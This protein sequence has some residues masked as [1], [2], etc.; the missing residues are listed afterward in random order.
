MIRKC[1]LAKGMFSRKI[2]LA[3][4]IQSKIGGRT[5]RSKFSVVNIEYIV[6]GRLITIQFIHT[7]MTVHIQN[8]FS[9]IHFAS[10]GQILVLWWT[11]NSHN[12][13]FPRWLFL[14]WFA[15]DLWKLGHER[16]LLIV[17]AIPL[18]PFCCRVTVCAVVLVI[19]LLQLIC[20][21]VMLHG[22]PQIATTFKCIFFKWKCT[23]SV[24]ISLKFFLSFKLTRHL[25]HQW[26]R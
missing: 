13:W 25:F 11:K 24:K 7:W 9:E 12:W 26:F 6:H 4:D 19:Y 20:L 1:S 8:E 21:L 16:T 15:K 22:V 18:C 3:K 10:I 5:P 14:D 17:S 2:S 23:N